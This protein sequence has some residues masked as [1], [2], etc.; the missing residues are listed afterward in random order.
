M[1]RKREKSDSGQALI[2]TSLIITML[3]LS[4][5]YYVFEME[6]N[7]TD[8]S[9]SL[10]YAF[11]STKLSTFNTVVSAL[12]NA[13]NGGN[14]SI[15]TADLS[16]L[17]SAL[18]SHSYDGETR[19]LFMPLNAASYQDGIETSWGSSGL[20]ISSAYVNFILNESASSMSYFS[21]YAAN[22]TTALIVQGT[23]AGNDSE[24]TVNAACRLYSEQGFELA[25]NI[26]MLYQNE[27]DGLWIPVTLSDN[28]V[29][30]YGNGTYSVSFN[31]YAQ[32]SLEVSAQ[33][34]DS[35]G[36]FVMANATCNLV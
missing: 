22:V 33:V 36:I 1:K 30:D 12:A 15:L 6:N 28:D 13:S 17:V 26:K 9:T 11:S 7:V 32:S 5:A 35:R 10:D 24:K 16:R 2:I 18:E 8:D 21:E 3:L 4:T 34:H 19:L 27:T 29:I 23:L 25:N 14:A 20:G 31:V